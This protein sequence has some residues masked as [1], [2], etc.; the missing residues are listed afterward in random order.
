MVVGR[1]EPDKKMSGKEREG[2]K[3]RRMAT[4]YMAVALDGKES[5]T[6]LP[7]PLTFD[8][9]ESVK[10]GNKRRAAVDSLYKLWMLLSPI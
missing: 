9:H 5:V 4:I 6:R 2:I 3:K 1:E 10:G 8:E 7:A